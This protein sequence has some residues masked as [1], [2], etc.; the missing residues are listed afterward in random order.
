[1]LDVR[2]LGHASWAT[3]LFQRGS[4][5]LTDLVFALGARQCS[6]V[7]SKKPH[8]KALMLLLL[9]SNVG[10]FIVDHIH[11]QYNGLLSGLLLLSISSLASHRFLMSG[12]LFSGLLMFKHI[13]LYIAPAFIVY[14]FRNY[15]FKTAGGR[16]VWSSFSLTRLILLG[17]SVM[18]N[19]T[20]AM[21]PFILTDNLS[22]VIS[23]LFP[24]KRGLCHAYWAPNLWAIYNVIDKV[25]NTSTS[26]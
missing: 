21:A 20:A 13:Y 6:E 5:I 2:S 23:R 14:M 16:V 19:V 15:C 17:L 22:N 24:F 4:V 25:G 11:F 1:M 9:L 7:L 10:L 8:Q 26:S 18:V 3:I 12:L